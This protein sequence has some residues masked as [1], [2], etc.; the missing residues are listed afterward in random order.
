MDRLAGLLLV[1]KSCARESCRKPWEVLSDAYKNGET[2][3]FP[4]AGGQDP[5]GGTAFRSL[6][7]AMDRR[8]DKFFASLPRFGFQMCLPYQLASNEGPFFPASSE[9]L[10][11]KYRQAVD[12]FSYFRVES[13]MPMDSMDGFGDAAQR[14]AGVDDVY[15]GARTLSEAEMGWETEL[16][17]APDY[18]GQVEEED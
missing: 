11:R 18:C 3:F 12:D 4:A 13:S 8:F 7:Q 1:T 15:K 10:G 16:C 9:D 14:F 6:Q 2:G 17:Q 5:I